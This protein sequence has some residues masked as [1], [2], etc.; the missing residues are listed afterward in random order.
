MRL[1]FGANGQESYVEMPNPLH[2]Q[3]LNEGATLSF[4]VKRSDDNHWDALFGV[5]SGNA[6]FYMTGNT[7]LG[8]NDGQ[9][10]GT[11]NWVDINHPTAVTPSTL[12]VGQWHL[13]TLTIARNGIKMYVDGDL[14]WDRNWKRAVEKPAYFKW[15]LEMERPVI[16]SIESHSGNPVDEE[17]PGEFLIDYV[18][19]YQAK[20]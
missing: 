2:G 10:S 17:L 19:F 9:T 1:N 18:R 8:Y 20:E 11:N 5:V 15:A 14:Y 7:Y 4:W 6:R 13:V 12:S 16:L 3:T